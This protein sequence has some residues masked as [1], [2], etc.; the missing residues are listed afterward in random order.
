MRKAFRHTGVLMMVGVVALG[1]LGA[2]YT[3]WYEQLTLNTTISTGTLDA[4]WSFHSWDGANFA[5]T[6]SASGNGKPVV[7]LLNPATTLE[8]GVAT[9][10]G[11][12]GSSSGYD[13]FTNANFP[14]GKPQPGCTGSITTD[15]GTG[16]ANDAADN[17]V[18]NLTMTGLYP[19]AGC[20]FQI[21]ISN[22]GSVPI[23][24]SILD[25]DGWACEPNATSPSDLS[26]APMTDF[27]WTRGFDLDLGNDVA[28]CRGFFGAE[29]PWN[30]SPGQINEF[31]SPTP[32]T[33]TAVQIHP[34]DPMLCGV[35][36]I[37]DQ[38][39]DAEGKTY[40]VKIRYA[41]YQ[42]NE[43]PSPSIFP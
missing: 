39:A 13:L 35:K 19:Y 18:L 9:V 38:N 12:G 11:L 1:L 17:N 5:A 6:S 16:Q 27:P 23:H 40:F 29:W 8:G 7:Y 34:D 37:L 14:A 26:C 2:A 32:A 36:F 41:A 28:K 31:A 20:E 24:L 4:D 30:P 43:V 10:M 22:A 3:L 15:N 42:W 33:P 21:D 25:V